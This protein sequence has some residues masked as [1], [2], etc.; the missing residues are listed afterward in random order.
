MKKFLWAAVLTLVS[1]AMMSCGD[2]DQMYR[3]MYHGFKHSDENRR[4]KDPSYDPAQVSEEIQPTYEEYKRERALL[5]Q[6][7]E[8][9]DS[10]LLSE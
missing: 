6:G 7:N 1:V 4:T 9:S 3:G 10:D 8:S 5:L 2:N